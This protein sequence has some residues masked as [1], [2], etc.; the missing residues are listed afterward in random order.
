MRRSVAG[1][2]ALALVCVVTV[3]CP[4]TDRLL[5]GGGLAISG[6]GGGGSGAATLSF[7]VQPSTA[8]AGNIITPPIQVTVRDSLGNPDSAF[9]AAITMSIA[10]N[11][12]GGNLTGTR[13]IAP[14]NGIAAFGD[15]VIDKSGA[16][17]ILQASASGATSASS[18][19]FDIL[20]P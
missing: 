20:A 11:P 6:G 17:Y 3:A 19:T 15:L 12:V 5:G 10:F 8:T 1:M 14:V 16:G 9:T 18:N 2:T 7:T 4:Y 13:S